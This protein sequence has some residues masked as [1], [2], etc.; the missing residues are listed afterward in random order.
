MVVLGLV[1]MRI[2][3]VFK[4]EVGLDSQDKDQK[5]FGYE[6]LGE[7]GF[8]RFRR[9]WILADKD[10]DGWVGM[11]W[12]RSDWVGWQGL[13]VII[14]RGPDVN[15]KGWN[16]KGSKTLVLKLRTIR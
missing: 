8:L 7:I 11:I 9:D 3:R 6:G 14:G 4:D 10:K 1:W 16:V 12:I 15:G 2:Y 13:G 5:R